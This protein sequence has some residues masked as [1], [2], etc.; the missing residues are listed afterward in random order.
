MKIAEIF[1]KKGENKKR[2]IQII[3]IKKYFMICAFFHL[4][5][6]LAKI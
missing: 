5:H 1:E 2:Y 6:L 4:H 3:Y